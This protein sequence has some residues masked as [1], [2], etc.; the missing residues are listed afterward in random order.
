VALLR[1]LPELHEL[2]SANPTRKPARP[3]FRTHGLGLQGMSSCT[4]VQTQPSRPLACTDRIYSFYSRMMYSQ[5]LVGSN[6]TAVRTV[7][8]IEEKEF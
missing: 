8:Q 7:D 3:R 1:L 4:T 2:N 5:V 6:F